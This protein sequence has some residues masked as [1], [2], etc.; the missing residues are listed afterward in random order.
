MAVFNEGK[1]RKVVLTYQEER[2]LERVRG[3]HPGKMTDDVTEKLT[4]L[5]DADAASSVGKWL[6][7]HGVFNPAS[8]VYRGIT[9]DG[10]PVRV[11]IPR[12]VPSP[13]DGSPQ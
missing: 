2:L 6:A 11:T 9:T 5:L 1:T 3:L 10:Q 8:M 7:D 13:F 12:G 4:R